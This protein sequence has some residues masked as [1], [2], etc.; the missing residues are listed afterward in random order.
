MLQ[1][2]KINPKPCLPHLA[3][4][5]ADEA[6]EELLDAL[7]QVLVGLV[8][9][10]HLRRAYSELTYAGSGQPHATHTSQTV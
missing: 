4:R 10:Q 9:A 5:V 2:S 3:V 8:P 1:P 6:T 7:L